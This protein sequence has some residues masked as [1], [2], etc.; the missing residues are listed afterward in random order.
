MP[1]MHI[2]F[3]SLSPS[4]ISR[5][6]NSKSQTNFTCTF[7][8]T[9]LFSKTFDIILCL[10]LINC[11]SQPSKTSSIISAQLCL[12][13]YLLLAITLHAAKRCYIIFFCSP[14]SLIYH[15]YISDMR[16]FDISAPQL[17]HSTIFTIKYILQS[18]INRI[19]VEEFFST[20][21][22]I[23]LLVLYFS[24]DSISLA[25]SFS[26]IPLHL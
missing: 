1:Q 8:K 16:I 14:H 25:M 17:S 24:I 13:K 5:K 6:L 9:F 11:A 18:L 26:G 7:S 2:F 15:I 21:L 19:Q 12:A 3:F 4:I 22:Q 20:L 10:C 23:S